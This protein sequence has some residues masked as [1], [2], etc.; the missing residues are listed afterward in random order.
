MAQDATA[1]AIRTMDALDP[2]GKQL[3]DEVWLRAAGVDGW[4]ENYAARL[5]AGTVPEPVALTYRNLVA[6]SI[7][8][9]SEF[10]AER[11]E[12]HEGDGACTVRCCPE[13]NEYDRDAVVS[14]LLEELND[15][16]QRW[17]NCVDGS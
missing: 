1:K 5:I 13:C 10:L 17:L 6:R 14:W 16:R 9:V 11:C 4:G 7:D 15:R 3:F 12:R 2:E 8:L